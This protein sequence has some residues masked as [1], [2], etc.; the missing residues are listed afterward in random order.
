ME[1]HLEKNEI[2]S[3]LYQDETGHWHIQSNEEH[4]LGVAHLASVFASEFGMAPWGEVIGLLHDKGKESD[5]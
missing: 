2:I 3:H 1:K 5:I 4:T